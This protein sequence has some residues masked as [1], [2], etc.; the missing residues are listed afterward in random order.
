ML[1]SSSYHQEKCTKTVAKMV[2]HH[3]ATV[4]VTIML[5]D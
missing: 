4:F 3:S 2:K 1:L 5:N